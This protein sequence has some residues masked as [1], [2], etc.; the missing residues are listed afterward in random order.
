MNHVSQHAF[1]AAQ[2]GNVVTQFLPNELKFN[3]TLVIKRLI[4]LICGEASMLSSSIR[5][6]FHLCMFV[7]FIWR[8]GPEPV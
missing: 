4:V 3:T 5:K 6:M 8:H 2:P 7:D 1:E